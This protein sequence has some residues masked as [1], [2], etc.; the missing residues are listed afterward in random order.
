MSIVVLLRGVNVGGH[1]V[2]R[3][4]QVAEKLKRLDVVNIGA[5]GTFIVRKKATQA[6]VRKAF[7]NELPFD[8]GIVLC[9]GTEIEELI[10]ND[11]FVR[12]KKGREI[13]RFV[14]ILARKPKQEPG[15]PF[16]VPL[17]DR[18][19]VKLIGRRGR[20][21]FGVYRRT[22]KTIRYLGSTDKL[23]DTTVTTRNWNTIQA[24]GKALQVQDI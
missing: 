4:K 13:V 7:S 1:R 22:M 2:F 3:P 24:I 21:V 16:A 19:L 8:T 10:A 9:P 11:P 5:A 6:E 17:A 23:F 15:Y 12:Q 18:W 14:S 20:Y